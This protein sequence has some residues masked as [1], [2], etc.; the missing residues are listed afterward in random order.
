MSSDAPEEEGYDMPSVPWFDEDSTQAPLVGS[1][2][3]SGAGSEADAAAGANEAAFAQGS[4][5]A[6][7]TA[8]TLDESPRAAGAPRRATTQGSTPPRPRLQDLGLIADGGMSTIRRVFDT[9]ILRK[10]ALKVLLPEL[11]S[12]KGSSLL[13]DEARVTGQL[14][15]PNIVPLYDLSF[16]HKG[17]PVFTMKL[18]DGCTFS[19][20][21][22]DRREQAAG[23]RRLQDLLQ[24]FLKVCDAV[25]FAHSRGVIH[26]DLKPDN[27]MV[28]SHGQVYVMDWGCALVV[29]TGDDKVDLDRR[30]GTGALEQRGI[31]VGTVAYMA[32]EQARGLTDE[33]DARADVF[34]LGAILYLI[35]TGSP[36][37]VAA[38]SSALL[39]MAQLGEVEPP[40]Q[41]A[42]GQALPEGLCQIAMKALATLPAER[43]GSVAQ[44]KEDVE[45]VLSEGLW[46]ASRA[47]AP[48]SLI[49]GEG[50]PADTAYIITAGECEVFR[51]EQGQRVVLR[52]MGPGEVF[53]ETA[54]LAQQPRSASVEAV[55]EV[56]TIVVTREALESELCKGSW[57]G[58]FVRAL[59]QRFRDVDARLSEMRRDSK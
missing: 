22:R 10:V 32:P 23:G 39:G 7:P 50:D 11:K 33:I 14:E 1:Q 58:A 47:F 26:R 46:L 5:D 6:E 9:N 53:G 48:G 52:R 54:I 49:F 56:T 34:S 8:L 3:G 35:L 15:H 37:Y 55:G 24:V 59:A 51:I 45:R 27:I 43:Y 16:D 30:L 13:L 31:V 21:L 25:S 57:A 12:V 17:A 18:V 36:P 44:L 42:R 40:G 28:G 41:R 29:E 19:Q 20:Y 4:R 2:A 38:N